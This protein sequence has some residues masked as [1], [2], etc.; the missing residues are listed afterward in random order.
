MVRWLKMI[1]EMRIYEA[2][3]GRLPDLHRRFETLTL[4]IWDRLEIKQAG[5]WTAEIGTSNELT[6]LVAWQSMAEREQKWGTFQSD[7]EWIAGRA[8]TEENG[9]LVAR[10][11]NSFLKPT[12]YSIVQ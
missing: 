12:P 11:R 4:K 6:Y 8:K 10:V 3:A 2:V 5:F 9:A 7:P 1:Y